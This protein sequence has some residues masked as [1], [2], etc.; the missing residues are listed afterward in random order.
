MEI[1]TRTAKAVDTYYSLKQCEKRRH[2][3][4]KATKEPNHMSLGR[5]RE[6]LEGTETENL[7]GDEK[8]FM[9]AFAKYHL[10][11]Q[12]RKVGEAKMHRMLIEDIYDKKDFRIREHRVQDRVRAAIMEEAEASGTVEIVSGW[13]GDVYAKVLGP[14]EVKSEKK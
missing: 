9:V 7:T 14:V 8:E 5:F 6:L 2:D 12:R 1:R 10:A 11:M 4:L 13:L 3:E